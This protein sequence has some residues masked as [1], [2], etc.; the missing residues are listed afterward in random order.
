MIYLSRGK[1][2]RHVWLLTAILLASSILAV[3]SAGCKNGRPQLKVYAVKYG[4]SLFPEEYVF[5][6]GS[7][8]R[9]LAFTWLCYYIEYKDKKI[10][11]DTGFENPSYI[12]LF[13][14]KDFILPV[15]I[16]KNNNIKPEDITDI[17]I[18]HGHFD[19]AGGISPY[20]NA[21]II[22]NDSELQQIK[23]GKFGKDTMSRFKDRGNITTFTDTFDLY[24]ILNVKRIGGH[25]AGSSVIYM[26]ADGQKFCFTGDEVYSAESIEKGI[27]NGTVAS[28]E[29]NKKFIKEYN[30]EYMPLTFHNG[31]YYSIRRQFI[32]IFPPDNTRY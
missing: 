15:E 18:T 4:A 2:M 14:I 10:L 29:N 3:F 24:G 28:L 12:K 30:K 19:H 6:G 11:I 23:N 31:V 32:Q 26:D 1:M 25:T 13:A 7:P 9:K 5:Q 20:I 21:R 16:L 8:A 27:P 22:I 17:I